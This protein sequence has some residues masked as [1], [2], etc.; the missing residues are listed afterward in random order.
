MSAIPSIRRCCISRL[1]HLSDQLMA[2]GGNPVEAWRLKATIA[3]LDNHPGMAVD[4]FRQAL[5][6]APDNADA[7]VGLAQALFRD[8]QPE[9]GERTARQ[10]VERHPQFASGYEV[11]YA[12]Y[13]AQQ[14]WDQAEALLKL[15]GAKN[16]KES[17]PILRLAAFYYSR[18]KPADAEQ[19]LQSMANRPA[20]FPHVDLQV[21]DFHA[22]TRNAEKALADYQRGET[23]DKER[24]EVYQERVAS[25][26]SA[27]GRR[28]EALKAVETMLAKDPK[29]LFAR[30]LKI[31]LLDQTGGPQNLNTAAG[32]AA[33]LAKETPANSTSPV[34]GRPNFPDERESGPGLSVFSASRE[35]RSA[36][37]CC[38]PGAGSY[39][40]ASKELSRCA[41]TCRRCVGDTGQRSQCAFVPRDRADGYALLRAS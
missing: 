13:A 7:A 40:T 3:L 22:L 12:Y 21:G 6:L 33:D 32:L 16:P 4:S 41:A 24:L 10:A 27:M 8:N 35:S 38:A 19:L 23:R 1:K 34:A 5:R 28:D 14:N 17:A 15:W 39:G 36:L 20:D 2:P 25:M 9:E 29:N 31:Q 37:F 30:A 18:Q 26:L 11:L